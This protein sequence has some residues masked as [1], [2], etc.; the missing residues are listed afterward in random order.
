MVERDPYVPLPVGQFNILTGEVGFDHDNPNSNY[1]TANPAPEN[2]DLAKIEPDEHDPD[3]YR[4]HEEYNFDPVKLRKVAERMVD[5]SLKIKNIPWP[6]GDQEDKR[7]PERNR[8]VIQFH[9]TGWQLASMV[10]EIARERGAFVII[11]F[12]DADIKNQVLSNI[13]PGGDFVLP[14]G[15]K[16]NDELKYRRHRSKK[17]IDKYRVETF[18]NEGI[19]K[20][21]R[22]DIAWATDIFII[23]NKA[24][25]EFQIDKAVQAVNAQATKKN[26]DARLK[27]NW[28]L[29][30]VPT[31]EEVGLMGDKY[32]MDEYVNMILEA[33]NRPWDEVEAAQ[34]I[35]VDILKNGDLLEISSPAPEGF[36]DRFRVD[37]KMSIKGKVFANSVVQRNFPGSEVFAAPNEGTLNGHFG[38]PYPVMFD[39]G[40]YGKRILPNVW[41]VF[42]NGR[43]DINESGTEGS[44][45]DKAFLKKVLTIDPGAAGIGEIGFGTNPLLDAVPNT[46]FAEKALGI[47]FALGDA[48]RNKE[49]N[50]R[51]VNLDNGNKSQIHIDVPRV[52]T[53]KY[54]DQSMGKSQIKLDGRVIQENGRFMDAR[55]RVLWDRDYN[56]QRAAA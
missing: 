44:E 50:G 38:V 49:Y 32:T 11:R 30:Y 31:L 19:A 51:Q 55:L 26:T 6:A 25:S 28:L 17:Q 24:S 15:A 10:A 52:L 23:R 22:D 46:L 9:S 43:V 1:R 18:I 36:D 40:P 56:K 13:E 3:F 42:K 7:A 27:K 41:L 21:E 33:G 35:L 12:N 29:T 45:E 20:D 54:A 48:Y 53:E 47:H 8:L 2:S 5:Q 4:S 39:A 37:V 14:L 34:D 16:E